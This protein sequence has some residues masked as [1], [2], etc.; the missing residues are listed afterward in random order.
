[1]AAIE[2]GL[3]TLG[4]ERFL[5]LTVNDLRGNITLTLVFSLTG[6]I[7]GHHLLRTSPSP[8]ALIAL[9][10]SFE[11]VRREEPRGWNA[12]VQRSLW[13]SHVQVLSSSSLA[14]TIPQ[15]LH[16][17]LSASEVVRL[18]LP[19]LA[20]SCGRVLELT[21]STSLLIRKPELAVL[22]GLPSSGPI[23]GG[24]TV[25]VFVSGSS[26]TSLECTFGSLPP[27]VGVPDT[28]SPGWFSCDTPAAEI[29]G[30]VDLRVLQKSD[31]R[32]ELAR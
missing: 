21:P 22:D 7:V 27:R 11:S 3:H 17:S 18:T 28:K 6:D 4:S 15:A 30:T 23:S 29:A 16:Y 14:I 31:L 10:A 9:A 2:N 24:T 8:V 5:P 26:P 13:S 32:G 12:V 20:L 19:A 25:R 1:M